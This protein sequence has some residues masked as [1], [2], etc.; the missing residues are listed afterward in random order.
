MINGKTV[1]VKLINIEFI[2][3]WQDDTLFWYYPSNHFTHTPVHA[4]I[5]TVEIFHPLCTGMWCLFKYK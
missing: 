3:Q 2:E 1:H 5:Y 4:H